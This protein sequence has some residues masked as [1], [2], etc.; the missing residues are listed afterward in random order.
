MAEGDVCFNRNGKLV[1]PKRLPSG[2][3]QFRPGTGEERCVFYFGLKLQHQ[4]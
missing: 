3:Y 4:T 2:L 1:R